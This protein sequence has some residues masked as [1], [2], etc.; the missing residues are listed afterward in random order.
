MASDLALLYAGKASRWNTSFLFT[1]QMLPALVQRILQAPIRLR[2]GEIVVLTR[3]ET[4]LGPIEAGI[5]RKIREQTTLCPAPAVGTAVV[6]YRVQ[7]EGG[8]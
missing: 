1:D 4:T 8:C 2:P 7:G 5:L 3:D 6:A